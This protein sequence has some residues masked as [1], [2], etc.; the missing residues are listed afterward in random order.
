MSA[1]AWRLPMIEITPMHWALWGHLARQ[2]WEHEAGMPSGTLARFSRVAREPSLYDL[3]AIAPADEDVADAIG[4]GMRWLRG[5]DQ[6]RWA[7]VRARVLAASDHARMQRLADR[8]DLSPGRVSQLA[9][10]GQRLV[11]EWVERQ[12]ES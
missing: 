4:R 5:R 7:A 12:W 9:T 1:A 3:Y 2:R 8:W 11:E 10:E 6:R